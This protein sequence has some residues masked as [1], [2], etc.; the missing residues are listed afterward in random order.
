MLQ[1]PIGIPFFLKEGDFAIHLLKHPITTHATTKKTNT[2]KKY[3][4]LL[5]QNKATTTSNPFNCNMKALP[6]KS[7][8]EE[9]GY[10]HGNTNSHLNISNQPLQHAKSNIETS[11]IL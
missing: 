9:E 11:Q 3:N 4:L 5:K 6:S 8:R 1:R 10:H 7:A 2:T